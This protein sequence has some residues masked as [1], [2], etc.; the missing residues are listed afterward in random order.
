VITENLET[1]KTHFGDDLDASRLFNPLAV[2]ADEVS[3]VSVKM[4]DVVSSTLA[5]TSNCNI[6]SDVGK[7]L[8]LMYVLPVTIASAERSFPSLRLLKMYLRTTMSAQSLNHI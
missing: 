2:L 5:F 4:K 8:Q 6:F 3:G 1:V 7:V